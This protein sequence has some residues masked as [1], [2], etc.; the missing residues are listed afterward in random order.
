MRFD[1]RPSH[2]HAYLDDYFRASMRCDGVVV[3][4]IEDYAD[5][6]FGQVCSEVCQEPHRPG[7]DV[8]LWQ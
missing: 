4:G 5:V 1:R 6:M 7:A 2:S 8:S 3:S